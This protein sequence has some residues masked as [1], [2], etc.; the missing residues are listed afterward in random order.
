MTTGLYL[1]FLGAALAAGLAGIGSAIGVSMAGQA[2]AGITKENPE[3]F[4]KLLVLQLLPATQG[5]Y[6]LLVAFIVFLQVGLIGGE[7]FVEVDLYDGIIILLGCLPIAVV[8]LISAIY[9]AKV[10]ISGMSLVAKRDE[11]SGKAILMGVMVETYAVLALLVSFLVV[12]F[13]LQA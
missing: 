4:S 10:V 13:T 2:A 3:K 11:D 6:G 5:I 12:F 9:Q 7:G 1:A 8:G